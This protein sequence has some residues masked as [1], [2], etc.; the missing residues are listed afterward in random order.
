MPFRICSS[1]IS[2]SGA[3]IEVDKMPKVLGNNTLLQNYFRN[4]ISNS[5]KFIGEDQLPRINI[6]WEDGGDGFCRICLKDNGIGFPM[7]KKDK[8]LK[9]FG[10]LNKKRRV[11]RQWHW[12]GFMS[13]NC[14]SA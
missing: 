11:P 3:I 1:K 9:L 4:L 6:K 10:R 13:E 7:D 12:L 5:L 2:Q 14:S 8:A